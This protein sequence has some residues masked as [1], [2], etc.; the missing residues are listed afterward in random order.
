MA[1]QGDGTIGLLVLGFLVLLALSWIDNRRRHA[2]YA[3]DVADEA[4]EA[5]DISETIDRMQAAAD[6]ADEIL[7]EF[8]SRR[9]DS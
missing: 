5:E 3:R 8:K 4:G 2:A 1:D 9:G 7:R 6:H